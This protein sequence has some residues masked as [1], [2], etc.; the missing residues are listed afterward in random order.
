M[1]RLNYGVAVD[2]A[3]NY[4]VIDTSNSPG[5]R[6]D[7]SSLLAEP[8]TYYVAPHHFIDHLFKIDHLNGAPYNHMRAMILKLQGEQLKD[9]ILNWHGVKKLVKKPSWA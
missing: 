3:G 4:Q 2:Y 9:A 1:A 5:V 8:F 7:Y 6:D